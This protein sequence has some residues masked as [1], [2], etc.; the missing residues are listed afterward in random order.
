MEPVSKDDDSLSPF[1]DYGRLPLGAACIGERY[2]DDEEP[3]EDVRARH[4]AMI[5]AAA[6]SE[7]GK[8]RQRA[9]EARKRVR[10]GLA[11][12]KAAERAGRQVKRATIEGFTIEF[13]APET[14]PEPSSVETPE[15]LRRLI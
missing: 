13:G 11:I 2:A 8:R 12:V 6:E 7:R 10:E 14:A 3:W 4:D 5:R 1:N 15:Q 9:A